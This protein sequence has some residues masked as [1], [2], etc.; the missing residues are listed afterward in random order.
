MN[1]C[2]VF[3]L[4]PDDEPIILSIKTSIWLREKNN[5]IIPHHMIFISQFPTSCDA[6][7]TEHT[8][9]CHLSSLFPSI[10]GS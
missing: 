9:Q 8:V 1:F 7:I 4:I 6:Y 5:Q 3:Q 10:T 2:V